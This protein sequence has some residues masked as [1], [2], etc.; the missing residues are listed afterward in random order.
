MQHKLIKLPIILNT[1][2][3]RSNMWITYYLRDIIAVIN[4]QKVNML[5]E[6]YTIYSH[7]KGVLSDKLAQFTFAAFFNLAQYL[8]KNAKCNNT[9]TSKTF[10][11]VFESSNQYLSTLYKKI[12]LAKFF[13]RRQKALLYRCFM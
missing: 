13:T 12:G 11:H 1:V 9:T 10:S 7:E 8:Y 6:L 2:R 5:V 4:T 3:F